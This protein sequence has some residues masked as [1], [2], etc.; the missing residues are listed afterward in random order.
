MIK[1]FYI[2]FLLFIGEAVYSQDLHMTQFYATPLNLNPAYTGAGACNRIGLAYR[3][4]WGVIGKGY[5]TN[6]LYYDHYLSNYNSGIGFHYIKDVSGTSALR[7]DNLSG[8]YAYE[9]ALSRK[10]AARFGVQAGMQ[11]NSIYYKDLIFGDQLVRGGAVITVEEIPKPKRYFDAS[12]GILVYSANSWLGFSVNHLTR[13]N[14]S[15]VGGVSKLPMKVSVHGGGKTIHKSD[16]DENS[17]AVQLNYAFNYKAQNEFDQLD[18]GM[19]AVKS[20]VHL[21]LWYR[22]IP[23][24]KSYKKG[25]PNNDAIAFILGYSINRFNIGYSYDLTI[26]WL[27]FR[28]AGAHE[29]TMNYQ[30]CDPKAKKKKKRVVVSC[31]KF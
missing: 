8:F 31:P 30:I 28:T 13:P 25:Y 22:G 4:Q 26:S 23:L 16:E 12:S 7:K 18:I 17:K 14:E 29:V 24:L 27:T 5:A 6:M 20:N 15:L 21:G 11:Q 19:Y 2:L 10:Y 3:N 1:R 9:I